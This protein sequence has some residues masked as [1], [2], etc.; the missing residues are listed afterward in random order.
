MD[1]IILNMR[2]RIHYIR[3]VPFFFFFFNTLQ[4]CCRDFRR[5]FVVQ[6]RHQ[7]TSS[8]QHRVHEKSVH[9]TVKLIENSARSRVRAACDPF[10]KRYKHQTGGAMVRVE[11]VKFAE[12]TRR[13][14]DSDG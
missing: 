7:N 13:T 10:S 3:Q 4:C 14:N 11:L 9:K 5:Y 12:K 8:V 6:R 1:I 2:A